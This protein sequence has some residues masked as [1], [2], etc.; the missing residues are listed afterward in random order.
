MRRIFYR[1]QATLALA[2]VFAGLPMSAAAAPGPRCFQ[3]T[4]QCLE[5]RFL[6]Y[7]EQNGGLPVF[8]YPVRPMAGEYNVDLGRSFVTQWFERGRFELHPENPRPYD[9]LLGRL[10]ADVLRK[11]NIDWQTEPR[12]SGPQ[13]DC[14]WFAETQHAVCNQASGIGFKTYWQTHGLEFDGR[15][16]VSYAESLALFGLPLTEPR[17]ETNSSGDR[18]LTQ[19]F[20]R[21]RFEW[22]PDQPDQYKVL[23]GLLGNEA[24]VPFIR[25]SNPGLPGRLLVLSD[26]FYTVKADGSR[27]TRLP[28]GWPGSG[29]FAISP[30]ARRMAT[31]CSHN[32]AEGLCTI[33]LGTGAITRLNADSSV[34]VAS[35]SP[36]G[37]RIAYESGSADQRGLHVINAD[38]SGD[39]LLMAGTPGRMQSG[40]SWSPDGKRLAFATI[41]SE[42]AIYVV[43]AD[44][45][46]LRQIAAEG[47]A[48]TWSPDGSSIAFES[49]S[50][51]NWDVYVV[52]PDGTGLTALT[53]S[54][55][56]ELGPV[57]S[58]DG[59][60]LA[61]AWSGP[62]IP[63]GAGGNQMVVYVMQ[64]NGGNSVKVL[65][66]EGTNRIDR[67]A[68]SPDG[69]YVAVG[70]FGCPRLGCAASV[71][72][73]ASDGTR[74]FTMLRG[75][76]SS[77]GAALIGWLPE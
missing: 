56:P 22:H 69:A 49:E 70:L 10:G 53:S 74:S 68:W 42:N 3:E 18:V 13:P 21:G 12:G 48:P 35:W 57:W 1:L 23:L 32:G 38:G 44:G 25:H 46:N 15:R 66:H 33:D 39:I 28:L 36:D 29:G 37:T 55:E 75:E 71:L 40:G 6:A 59:R 26:Q 17:M 19:W 64:A 7:W 58:P 60:R 27:V 45:A 34:V 73:A 54:P 24:R 16:G 8:G 2:L 65:H 41:Y 14:L 20:E 43:N 11:M 62:A 52:R 5:G 77:G 4:G 51:G 31:R 63:P 61:Y 47:R 67:V 30:D 76:G 72:G 50:S 9:V